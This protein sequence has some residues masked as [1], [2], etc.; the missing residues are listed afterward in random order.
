MFALI[1]PHQQ[2][3]IDEEI[4]NFTSNTDFVGKL[5][6]RTNS[7]VPYQNN[8]NSVVSPSLQ[9]KVGQ[10]VSEPGEMPGVRADYHL[11][12]PPAL[13]PLP[14]PRRLLPLLPLSPHF[15]QYQATGMLTEKNKLIK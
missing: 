12:H 2:H 1:P 3:L 4:H 11:L 14:G 9:E 10:D 5:T 15:R 13:P 7:L 8:I 6:S